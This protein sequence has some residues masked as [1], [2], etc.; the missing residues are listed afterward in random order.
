VAGVLFRMFLGRWF[1]SNQ[2]YAIMQKE[3]RPNEWGE[4]M[5]LFESVNSCLRLGD[6]KIPW[7]GWFDIGTEVEIV[8]VIEEKS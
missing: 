1:E 3:E 6:K 4:R 8:K 5:A 2:P 7:G